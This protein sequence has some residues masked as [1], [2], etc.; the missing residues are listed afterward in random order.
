MPFAPLTTNIPMLRVIPSLVAAARL[1]APALALC[2]KTAPARTF[3]PRPNIVLI[4][5]DDLGF[6]HLGCYGQKHIATP[7]LDKLASQGMRFTQAYAGASNCGPSRASLLTGMHGGHTSMRQ[8]DGGIPLAAGE[9]TLAAVLQG[10]GYA[11]GGFGKWGLGDFGTVGVPWERGFDRFFG[12]L[13]QKHAHF[14]YTD[15]LWDNDRKFFLTGNADGRQQQYSHDVIMDRAKQFIRER[16]NGPFFCYLPFTLPHH[17]FIVPESSLAEYRGKFEEHPL[18]K[19]REGYANPKEPT[20]TLAAMISHLDRSVGKI[21]ALLDQLGI[22]DNT[23]VIFTSD[24]GG[25]NGALTST[26]FF[27]PNGDLRGYKQEL[28]EG[29]IRVPAIIRWPHVIP[30]GI[31]TSKVWYFADVMPTLADIAGATAGV[32]RHIDGISFRQTL[33][34]ATARQKEPAYR[35]WEKEDRNGDIAQALRAGDWKLISF[36][37]GGKTRTELYNLT[38]D[39]REQHDLAASEPDRAAHL[40]HLLTGARTPPPPQ[41]EPSRPTGMDYR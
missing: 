37:A 1:L 36:K 8:N 39:P 9:I 22:A 7:H 23:V 15:Y 28:Y 27:R 17:E 3:S 31:V 5:A 38:R 35:Y 40:R 30:P 25:D 29:G 12:Y 2:F 18:P 20:A 26:E 4:V 34:G 33:I 16:R 11:T 21:M 13:H 10:A 24:N 41:I 19:W 14:Y 32:P 6:G